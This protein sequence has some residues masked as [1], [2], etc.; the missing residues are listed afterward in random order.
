MLPALLF[1]F[2]VQS[3]AGKLLLAALIGGVVTTGALLYL[4]HKFTKGYEQHISELHTQLQQEQDKRTACEEELGKLKMNYEEKLRKY[5]EEVSKLVEKFLK[6]EPYR[7]PD[8]G[9]PCEK[10][11]QLLR[12]FQK[13]E[14]TSNK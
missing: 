9:T 13:R 8:K 4:Q 1:R 14:Q 6:E 11:L 12:E 7:V 10:I 3:T 5:Q 2:L